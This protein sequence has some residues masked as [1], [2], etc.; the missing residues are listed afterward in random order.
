MT[1]K[2]PVFYKPEISE[3]FNTLIQAA[4][5]KIFIIIQNVYSL[6]EE[7]TASIDNVAACYHE[8]IWT[9]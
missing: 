1:N 7:P 5:F 6:G 9:L 4:L 8:I 2:F 3:T